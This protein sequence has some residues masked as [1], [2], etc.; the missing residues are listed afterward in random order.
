MNSGTG[1]GTMLRNGLHREAPV[2]WTAYLP[3][4]WTPIDY[5][6]RANRMFHPNSAGQSRFTAQNRDLGHPIIH[7]GNR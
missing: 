1:F 5:R 3:P 7:T 2:K 4:A 6:L